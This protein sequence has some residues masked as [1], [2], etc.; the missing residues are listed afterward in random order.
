[1]SE[2]P[3]TVI[4]VRG[5]DRAKL[6]ADPLFVYVGRG[7]FG[8]KKSP[9]ANPYKIVDWGLT[10]AILKFREDLEAT[11]A[12]SRA[13]PRLL[14]ESRVGEV[15]HHDGKFHHMASRLPELCGK[16]L[17]CWC[18]DWRPGEPEIPC[19]AVVLAKLA[20]SF[21]GIPAR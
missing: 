16:R 10:L 12:G 8:W 14:P 1:M 17:G 6:L 18:G 9:F 13:K 21:A 15:V 7:C 3:T 2:K 5:K 20:D 11:V 4:C 19:H